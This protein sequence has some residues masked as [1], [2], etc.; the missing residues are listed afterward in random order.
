[1]EIVTPYSLVGENL[2]RKMAFD[3][4]WDISNSATVR[5]PFELWRHRL[6]GCLTL[7]GKA[8]KLNVDRNSEFVLHFQSNPALL[9]CQDAV[10]SLFMRA[11]K[12]YD[13]IPTSSKLVVFDTHLPVRKAFFALVYNG[14]RAAPLWDSD[15]QRFVGMLTITDFIKILIRWATGSLNCLTVAF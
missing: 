7:L 5:Q 15:K 4:F 6:Y 9:D 3:A 2:P 12:C 8:S 11:H 10:Y 13:L 1:M 14:V